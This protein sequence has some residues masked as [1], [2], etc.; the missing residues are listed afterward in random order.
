M[1]DE[2]RRAEL[3]ERGAGSQVWRLKPP[4]DRSGL[5]GE[6]QHPV[7]GL[8]AWSQVF[9]HSSEEAG[10]GTPRTILGGASPAVG[11]WPLQVGGFDH[12]APRPLTEAPDPRRMG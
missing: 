8:K 9:Q 10:P 2:D 3:L 6:V 7:S 4:P 5:S 11:F 1:M 12:R